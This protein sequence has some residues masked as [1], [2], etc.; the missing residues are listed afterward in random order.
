MKKFTK[1]LVY[2]FEGSNDLTKLAEEFSNKVTT[3]TAS[4]DYKDLLTKK[5]FSGVE[6]F[7]T[8]VFDNFNNELFDLNDLEYIGTNFTDL[9]M[10][11]VAFLEKNGVSVKNINGQATE[12]V[13]QF[14]LSILL[15]IMRK[16]AESLA[17]A[18]QGGH[19]FSNF[20]GTELGSKHVAV[21]GLGS[22]G[23]RFAD[24][25]ANF[26]ATI[27]HASRSDKDGYERKELNKLINK[28]DVLVITVPLTENT[29]GSITGELLSKINNDA[30]I[31]CPTR[32]DVLDVSALIDYL[33]SNPQSTFWMDG[34]H[35]DAWDK[36]HAEL[37]KL[38]NFLVTPGN[39]FFTEE[40]RPRALELTRGNINQFLTQTLE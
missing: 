14:M 19:G 25:C 29:K 16:T 38:E 34:N 28:A 30:I 27:T 10:F 39:G 40:N 5:D 11:D 7:L 13:S 22:I 8:D 33:K 18:K 20:K 17:Y 24:T 9:A 4:D 36:Y 3:K 32:L 26:G 2:E 37:L 6:C 23:K 31:L 12:P 21:Y 1:T 15:N 35:G